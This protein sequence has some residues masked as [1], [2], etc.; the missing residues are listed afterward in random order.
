MNDFGINQFSTGVAMQ[1]S[2]QANEKAAIFG[3][4]IEVMRDS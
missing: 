4:D 2:V 1:S 3:K